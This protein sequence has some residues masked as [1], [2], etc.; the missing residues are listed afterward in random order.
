MS[1]NLCFF[2]QK[3][4]CTWTIRYAN[5]LELL[6]LKCLHFNTGV[7]GGDGGP[8]MF[9]LYVGGIFCAGY[10]LEMLDFMHRGIFSADVV[11]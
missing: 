1:L 2:V 5:V 10:G 9:D 6:D 3:L 8:G 4:L 7:F 11:L